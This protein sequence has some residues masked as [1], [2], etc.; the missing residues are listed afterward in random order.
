MRTQGYMRLYDQGVKSQ[1]QSWFPPK[2]CA[3]IH[4]PACSPAQSPSQR[5][6]PKQR[7]ELSKG[8]PSSSSC[9]SL[10]IGYIRGTDS[11]AKRCVMRHGGREAVQQRKLKITIFFP[12]FLVLKPGK[13]SE[14]APVLNHWKKRNFKISVS[15]ISIQQQPDP[16]RSYSQL[17][18]FNLLPRIK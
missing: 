5:Q 6:K 14:T 16:V 18:L 7:T 12:F 13:S 17:T 4:A 8:T 3:H 10:V 15:W 11:T 1:Q 9:S 2:S